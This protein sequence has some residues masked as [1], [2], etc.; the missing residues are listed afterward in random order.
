MTDQYPARFEIAKGDKL[1]HIDW[2]SSPLAEHHDMHV[3]EYEVSR[4]APKSFLAVRTKIGPH[5][6]K[7]RFEDRHDKCTL[8]RAY[9]RTARE[10]LE[11]YIEAQLREQG[12]AEARAQ[13][14]AGLVVWAKEQLGKDALA[15]HDE[16]ESRIDAAIEQLR[17]TPDRS[18]EGRWKYFA[19][20]TSSYWS[21]TRDSL[22]D[23]GERLLR[24]DDRDA[25]YVSWA[26]SDKTAIEMRRD[27]M[28]P[29]I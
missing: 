15:D 23:F 19:E 26:E 6:C 21:V 13:K 3:C 5:V 7:R 20:E 2:V 4:V 10:A 22:A 29:R 16:R 14:S 27:R 8:G 12:A 9:F 1:Y 11:S 24:G 17:A 25:A 18:T 28:E